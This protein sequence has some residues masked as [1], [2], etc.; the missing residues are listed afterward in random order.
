[1][2][3]IRMLDRY[4]P[5]ADVVF[6]TGDWVLDPFMGVGSTAIAALMHGRKVVGAELMPEYVA[7]ARERVMLAEQGRLRIRPMERAVYDPDEPAR[8]APPRIVQIG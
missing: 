8:S 4:A 6:Y 3:P 2:S 1:M 7:I 5:D